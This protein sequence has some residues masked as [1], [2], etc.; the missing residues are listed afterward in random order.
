MESEDARLFEGLR[1]FCE[2]N[3]L[4][5]GRVLAIT[6][7]RNHTGEYASLIADF[8]AGRLLTHY[9]AAA[10]STYKE[11]RRGDLN[12]CYNDD[13]PPLPAAAPAGDAADDNL[14]APFCCGRVTPYKPS[15]IDNEALFTYLVSGRGHHPNNFFQVT[16]QVD[17]GPII[18]QTFYQVVG[19]A[20][21]RAPAGGADGLLKVHSFKNYKCAAHNRFFGVDLFRAG[22]VRNRYHMR[23]NPF[24]FRNAEITD[25]L[26]G[27][28]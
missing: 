10:L 15:H 26:F 9:P 6:V 24:E 3:G 11:L 17:N 8:G 7:Q 12:V 18:A 13:L 5:T 14:S 23:L 4:G 25:A 16:R 1:R 19:N 21:Q 2:R 22:A 27:A 20:V 28:S